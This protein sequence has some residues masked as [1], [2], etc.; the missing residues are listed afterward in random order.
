MLLSFTSK[1]P[2]HSPI[3]FGIKKDVARRIITYTQQ[4][5]DQQADK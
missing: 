1:H 5:K 4:D 3:L 2:N